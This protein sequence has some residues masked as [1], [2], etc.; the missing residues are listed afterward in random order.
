MLNVYKSFGYYYVWP[1]SAQYTSIIVI[2]VNYAGLCCVITCSQLLGV[3]SLS[4]LRASTYF[5]SSRL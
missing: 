2:I 5:R 3:G 1:S 4:L